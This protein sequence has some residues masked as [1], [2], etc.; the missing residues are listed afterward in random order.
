M[1]IMPVFADFRLSKSYNRCILTLETFERKKDQP[2]KLNKR[3]E[4]CVSTKEIKCSYCITD[5]PTNKKMYIIVIRCLSL[6]GSE[7][8]VFHLK[9]LNTSYILHNQQINR[10]NVY[11]RNLHQNI[12]TLYKK[13][14]KKIILPLNVAKDEQVNWQTNAQRVRQT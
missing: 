3:W 5:R 4:N 1:R 10:Q 12:R 8:F 9:F 2:S 11:M 6:I 7:K 14:P 13:A